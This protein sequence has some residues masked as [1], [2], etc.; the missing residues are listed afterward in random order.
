[1]GHHRLVL[2]AALLLPL[3]LPAVEQYAF[4]DYEQ[5][6]P[7][8]WRQVYPDGGRTLY[9][10]RPFKGGRHRSVNVEHVLPMGWAMKAEGCRKR[11]QCRVSSPRFNRMEADLH[12]MYPALRR[13]NKA[14][15]SFPFAMIPGEE[16]AF[17]SCDFERDERRRRVEPRPAARGN[18][19]RAMF[20]M[21]ESYGLKIFRRQGEMLKRWNREDPPDAEERRRND[22][23]E[24]VQGTRN[25][26]IDDPRAADRLRF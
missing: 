9:C 14:R 20:H 18:I 23:I 5:A 12:N 3:T 1:M 16:R 7:V 4:K 24:R 15:G 11:E 21:K 25:R 22:A 17:G 26:F 10:N 8:F 19:A 2:V 6:R 13:I